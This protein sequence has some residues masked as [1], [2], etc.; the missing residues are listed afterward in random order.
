MWFNGKISSFQ[1][2]DDGSIPFTR[3]NVKKSPIFGDFLVRSIVDKNL[4]NTVYMLYF[5]CI[6]KYGKNPYLDIQIWQK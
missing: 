2:E 4:A 3:S 6:H 1:E 5:K